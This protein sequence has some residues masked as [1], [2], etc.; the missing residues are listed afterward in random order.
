[1][2][3]NEYTDV[4]LPAIELL[5]EL[6]YGYVDGRELAPENCSERKSLRDVVL[7]GK[8]RESLMRINPRLSDDNLNKVVRNITHINKASLLESNRHFYEMMVNYLSY[9]QDLG[10]GR[11]GQ[12][13]KL[14]DFD[15]PENNEFLAVNQFKVQGPKQNIIPDIVIFVNGLPLA[16]IECKSPYIVSEPMHCGIDQLQRY[17]NKRNPE[18]NEGAERL[19]NYNQVM[20]S[21][22]RDCAKLGT[23][24]S[25]AGHFLEWKDP[26]PLDIAKL[27]KTSKI[28]GRDASRCVQKRKFPQAYSQLY[29]I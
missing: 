20:V 24:S 12:T 6:G 27:G 23:I 16:V 10:K 25:S 9:D 14:I 3:N 28:P 8:L 22:Y 7:E 1:M 13:V 29:S 5:R 11:K 2:I 4:E 17:C 18:E 26:Y 19:F 15:T 21:T